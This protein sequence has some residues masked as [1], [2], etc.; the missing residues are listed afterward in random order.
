MPH[1][2]KTNSPAFVPWV[3]KALAQVKGVSVDDVAIATSR[4]FERLFK[5]PQ[6][7]TEAENS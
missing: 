2:G 3:A 7:E 4:N 1:R 5:L 6:F